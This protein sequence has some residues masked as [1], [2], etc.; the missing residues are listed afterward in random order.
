M[1]NKLK[2]SNIQLTCL[3]RSITLDIVRFLKNEKQLWYSL[4][5]SI[6]KLWLP[7][8]LPF[9]F[10][11][12]WKIIKSAKL[13]FLHSSSTWKQCWKWPKEDNNYRFVRNLHL[14]K[15]LYRAFLFQIFYLECE[16]YYKPLIYHLL[17][18][19]SL[20]IPSTAENRNS[21]F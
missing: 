14:P 10:P 2:I 11:N 1:R 19:I 18:I 9:P 17:I 15:D 21:L 16:K 12:I 6:T 5:I 8:S 13:N 7:F 3:P 20:K 4:T